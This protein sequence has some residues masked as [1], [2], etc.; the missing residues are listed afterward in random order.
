MGAARVSAIAF[1]GGMHFPATRRHRH[2]FHFG[3]RACESDER[4]KAKNKQ[5]WHR[6]GTWLTTISFLRQSSTAMWLG[7]ALGRSVF[8]QDE[9]KKVTVRCPAHEARRTAI[10]RWHASPSEE[11]GSARVMSVVRWSLPMLG[12]SFCLHLK[13]RASLWLG[14]AFPLLHAVSS[15]HLVTSVSSE[16]VFCCP[17]NTLLLMHS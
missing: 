1:A 2:A 7:V 17:H 15:T 14:C 3:K 16:V 5:V 6:L 4:S 11:I 12:R 8:S 13:R 10:E 9:G